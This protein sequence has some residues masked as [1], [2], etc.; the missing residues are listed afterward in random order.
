MEE[1]L[2]KMEASMVVRGLSPKTREAYRCQLRRLAQYHGKSP[3]ELMLPRT[4]VD[5][6]SRLLDDGHH[7]RCVGARS[8]A[9]G[10]AP[11]AWG[12]AGA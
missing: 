1:L 2:A 5:G 6:E 12:P 8:S 9:M 11:E 4:L 7:E 3:S 10:N